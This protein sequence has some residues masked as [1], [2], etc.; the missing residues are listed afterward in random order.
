MEGS[1]RVLSFWAAV[2]C[3]SCWFA[4]FGTAAEIIVAPFYIYISMRL[5]IDCPSCGRWVRLE[6]SA[7]GR[8]QCHIIFITRIHV[9]TRR[10]A[11]APAPKQAIGLLLHSGSRRR[12]GQQC[13]LLSGIV[14]KGI[15]RRTR[16]VGRRPHPPLLL[17]RL[18]Q[19]RSRP[20]GRHMQM[21]SRSALLSVM[22]GWG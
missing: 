15:T 11:I 7:S 2:A 21:L 22:L 1:F 18:L 12:C 14:C 13:R 4:R 5:R 10:R 16:T 17:L 3:R 19:W 20:S 6:C 8:G 9:A